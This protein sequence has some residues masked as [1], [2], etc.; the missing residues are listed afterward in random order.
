MRFFK[1]IST[2]VISG[3]LAAQGAHL[4]AQQVG[5][6]VS[7]QCAQPGMAED[8]CATPGSSLMR[9]GSAPAGSLPPVVS[10]PPIYGDDS[11]ATSGAP[12]Y[13]SGFSP[14]GSLG[15]NSN[16]FDNNFN[17]NNQSLGAGNNS[18][19]ADNRPSRDTFSSASR[20]GSGADDAAWR[21]TTIGDFFMGGSGIFGATWG[22]NDNQAGSMPVSGADRRFKLTEQTSPIPMNRL[23]FNYNHFANPIRDINGEERDLDRYTL[24]LEK[25]VLGGM[26]SLEVRVPI[27]A[28]LDATQT[29][30]AQSLGGTSLGNITLTPKVLLTQRGY[31]SLSAGVGINLPTGDDAVLFAPGANTPTLTIENESVHLLPF[32]GWQF[33]PNTRS[34]FTFYTQADFDPSGN[35]VR[36]VDPFTL[37]PNRV[38]TYNDQNLLFLDAS[39][40][41]WFYQTNNRQNILRGIA[42]ITELHYSTTLNN[43]DFALAGSDSNGDSLTNP[44][45]RQDILNATGGLRFAFGG[46]TTLTTA[47]VTPLRTDS[48]KQFDSEIVVQLNRRF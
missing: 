31:H 37:I 45:N 14:D 3:C 33:K 28:G 42:V 25:L 29:S 10:S 19:N 2:V 35:T 34:W 27:V 44:F 36:S 16:T 11:C 24:G 17:A 40:G 15:A 26:G 46:A 7:D 38:D 32:L 18:S 48:D 9:M 20:Q 12:D 4:G 8:G 30:G 13:S 47:V 21:D 1:S 39:L 41:R 5:F 22:L 23:F 6:R 43:T